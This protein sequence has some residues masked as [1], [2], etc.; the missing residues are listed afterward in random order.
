MPDDVPR[1]QLASIAAIADDMDRLLD[2]LF[3][4][5]AELKLIL[6]RPAPGTPEGKAGEN[7][8]RPGP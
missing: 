2:E 5:T 8:P 7:D 1:Q 6:T 4:T 3:A